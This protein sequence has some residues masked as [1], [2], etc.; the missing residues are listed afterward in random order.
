MTEGEKKSRDLIAGILK[1]IGGSMASLLSLAKAMIPAF[2]GLGIAIA[3]AFY[4]VT[5]T[6]AGFVAL[7]KVI[8]VINKH[9]E[10]GGTILGSLVALATLFALKMKLAGTNI[11][12]GLMKSLGGMKDKLKSAVSGGGAADAVKGGGMGESLAKGGKGMG[13]GLKGLSK[14]VGAFANPKV[15]LG[16]AAVTL[17]LI[18]M[19]FALKLAAP[20]IKAFGEAI[21]SIVKSVVPAIKAIGFVMGIMI[22]SIS[23]GISTIIG[24]IGDFAVK[25]MTV[26]SPTVAL[27]LFSTAAGFTALA[28]SMTLFA[29]AGLLALPALLAL[30]AFN[31][32]T[33]AGGGGEEDNKI[34]QLLTEQNQKLDMMNNQLKTI[35]S[36]TKRGAD[37]AKGFS[38]LVTFA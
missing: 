13:A 35:K 22:K 31:A 5:L 33:G 19:G 7:G 34:E 10:Y 32:V 6:I 9:F 8:E 15:A 1:F 12:G 14:G 38:D 18:G 17:S 25:L 16:L 3:V 21:S 20:G 26:A 36:N 2:V 4:P 11:G 27:G 23:K 37:E 24:A 30:T 28:G 29:G